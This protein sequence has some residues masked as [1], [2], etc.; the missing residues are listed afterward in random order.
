LDLDQDEET[1]N[2]GPR[3]RVLH[4]GEEAEYEGNKVIIDIYH[5]EKLF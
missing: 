2:K 5:C 4:C 1:S 3:K